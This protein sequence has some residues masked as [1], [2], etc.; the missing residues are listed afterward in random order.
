MVLVNG[1]K[2]RPSPSF[3]YP[4]L[5]ENDQGINLAKPELSIM[6]TGQSHRTGFVHQ[7]RIWRSAALT[8]LTQY[9][10][11]RSKVTSKYLVLPRA[12]MVRDWQT[13]GVGES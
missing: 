10:R 11:L 2:S 3:R 12:C 7:P 13:L 6:A 4:A 5:S 9:A 1:W 8:V